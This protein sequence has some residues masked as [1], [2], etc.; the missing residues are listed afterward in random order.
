MAT[1]ITI[2]AGAF[3]ASVGVIVLIGWFIDLHALTQIFPG[4]SAMN[5]ITAVMLILAGMAIVVH[6]RAPRSPIWA[7]STVIALV[8]TIKILELAGVQDFAIDELLFSAKLDDALG[9]PPNRMAPNTA[10]SLVLTGIALATSTARSIRA[11]LVSQSLCALLIAI[12]LFALIGYMLGIIELYGFTALNP[13]ALH[14]ACALLMIAIGV[15]SVNPDVG[16]LRVIGDRGPAGQLSRWALPLVVLVPVLVGILRLKAQKLG[17]YESGTGVAVQVFGNVLATFGLL[18]ISIMLLYKSD[19]ERRIRELAV[20][21]SE[22]EYRI[23]ERLGRVGHWRF[24]LRTR[25][26][27]CSA[28]L[29][30][31]C[32]LPKDASPSHR[33]IL[34]LH[35]PNDAAVQRACTWTA[36]CEG[37]GWDGTRRITRPDGRIRVI[38]SHEE[39]ETNEYGQTVSIFGVFVD[40]TELERSRQQAEAATAAKA[41]FLANMSHEIRTPLNSIIGFTDLMLDDDGIAPVH[42]RQLE[43]VRNSGGALLTVVNDILDFSKMEAGKVELV[44]RS[45]D[46]AYLVQNTVAIIRQSAQTKG[47]RIDVVVDPALHR[48]FL[49]DDR[50]LQQILLNLLSNAVKFTEAGGIALTVRKVSPTDGRQ[51]ISFVVTDSGIGIA[52][53]QAH[54]LFQQFSQTNPTISRQYGGTGLGL[55]I[56]KRLVTLMGGEIGFRPCPD[57]GGSQFWFDVSLEPTDEPLPR[58]SKS[59][60][61]A[62]HSQLSILVVEDVAVNQELAEAVLARLGHRVEIASNGR[63]AIAA[64]QEQDF[65]LVLM[66]LQMPIMDGITATKIIRLLPGRGRTVPIIA[67]TANILPEQV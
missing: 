15:L 52:P 42:R 64:V 67:L 25:K 53:S 23:A 61:K 14:T 57:G 1:R 34:S 50:R 62:L 65:D 4:M 20:K 40:I 31:I 46:L 16:I 30:S 58:R 17:Y 56:C 63:E 44:A 9:I 39:V 47:L 32:G 33:T 21:R 10:F 41:E 13:M 5:P 19:L 49:A 60:L 38:R 54:R 18:M 48:N 51:M 6:R 45:F 2:G 29:L 36:L 28:E 26:L 37:T 11:T 43:L 3:A 7:L 8:G 12:S 24:D 35:H 22:A 66:D 55:A 27:E 59:P